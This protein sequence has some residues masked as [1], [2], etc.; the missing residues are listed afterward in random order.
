MERKRYFFKLEMEQLSEDIWV[1]VKY[2]E[3]CAKIAGSK[4]IRN[5]CF[6]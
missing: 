3:Y 4:S 6:N 2:T 1:Q 5:S